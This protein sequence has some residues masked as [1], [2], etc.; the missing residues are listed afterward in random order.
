MAWWD[1][2]QSS[3]CL[4]ALDVKRRA[5]G[6]AVLAPGVVCSGC[7]KRRPTKRGQK[8]NFSWHGT[9]TTQ[10]IYIYILNVFSR[11]TW[12]KEAC[13]WSSG[14]QV[15]DVGFIGEFRCRNLSGKISERAAISRTVEDSIPVDLGCGNA[16]AKHSKMPLPAFKSGWCF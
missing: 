7:R 16:N 6:R 5:R 9:C 2:Q 13:T 12:V 10:N 11:L 15:A 4:V 3:R 1:P 14:R 8:R